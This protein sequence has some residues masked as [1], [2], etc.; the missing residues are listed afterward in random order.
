MK[1]A[2]E[3]LVKIL[4]P[5][6]PHICEELWQTMGGPGSIH[7]QPW[8][9]FDPKALVVAEVEVV[10]QI[11]GKVRGRIIVPVGTGQEELLALARQ[12]RKIRDYLEQGEVRKVILIPDKLLNLVV[13]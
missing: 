9:V 7:H 4:A 8:P 12:E 1:E 5:F 10:V 11:N 2:L 13:K 6:A 3:T